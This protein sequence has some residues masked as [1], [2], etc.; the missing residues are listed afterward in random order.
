MD[1]F[2]IEDDIPSK[3]I[4]EYTAEILQKGADYFVCNMDRDT[5]MMKIIKES[6]TK[7]APL[8]RK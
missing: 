4:D 2:V 5:I 3:K 7:D 8:W 1:F 6:Y